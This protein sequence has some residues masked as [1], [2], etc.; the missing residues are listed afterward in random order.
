MNPTGVGLVLKHGAVASRCPRSWLPYLTGSAEIRRRNLSLQR[1]DPSVKTNAAR[2]SNLGIVHP[3]GTSRIEKAATEYRTAC[4]Q[5]KVLEASKKALQERL[6]V[7]VRREGQED[8][9]GKL[10]YET[11]LHRFIIVGGKNVSVNGDKVR[12]LLI[13]KGVK[14]KIADACVTGGTKTTEYEYVRVDDR[15]TDEEE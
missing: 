5:I 7:M 6:V 15:P 10:R 4:E 8:E 9:K 14:P 13:K 12:Q 1:K 3:A 2:K 11:D